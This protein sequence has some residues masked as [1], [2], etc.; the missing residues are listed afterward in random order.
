AANA[1][2]AERIAAE[3]TAAGVCR[4]A[5]VAHGPVAGARVG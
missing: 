1:A 5:R 3:L 2:D 4:E